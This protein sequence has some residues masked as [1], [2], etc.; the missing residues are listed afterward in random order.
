M[1][2]KSCILLFHC[3]REL[4]NIYKIYEALICI[5]FINDAPHVICMRLFIAIDI[6]DEIRS[7]VIELQKSIRHLRISHVKPELMHITIKFL[8]EDEPERIIKRLERI[9]SEKFS[10]ELSNIGFFPKEKNMRVVWL[11]FKNDATIALKNA[12]DEAS[13]GITPPEKNYH[14]HL[15]LARIRNLNDDIR[16]SLSSF[17]K[18][19]IEKLS[20]PVDHFTLYKSTLLPN[21]PMYEEVRRFELR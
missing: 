2:S 13:H 21:G 4:S 15:T 11:G 3:L 16:N 6:T 12:I 8:G 10:L 19:K 5:T 9:Q 14:A 7:Y 1:M 18:L 20:F 17:A